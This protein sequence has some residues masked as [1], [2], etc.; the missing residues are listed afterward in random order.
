MSASRCRV[1]CSCG[2]GHGGRS[3]SSSSSCSRRRRGRPGAAGLH[4]AA[5]GDLERGVA[6]RHPLAPLPGQPAQAAGEAGRRSGSFRAHRRSSVRSGVDAATQGCWC[7]RAWPDIVCV[8]EHK[9][10]RQ[11]LTSQLCVAHGWRVARLWGQGR[12]THSSAQPTAQGTPALA[13]RAGRAILL[14]RGARPATAAWPRSAARTP[15]RCRRRRASPA[16]WRSTQVGA[17]ACQPP[18]GC[19]LC[20]ARPPPPRAARFGWR[21]LGVLLPQRLGPSCSSTRCGATA[22]WSSWR[23]WTRRGESWSRTT[24]RHGLPSPPVTQRLCVPAGALA[25]RC[26]GA[27]AHR[28]LASGHCKE[29]EAARGWRA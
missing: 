16:C 19:T 18:Q 14:A 25:A 11:D 28:V 2:S 20:F 27:A 17:P 9:L 4:D 24:V 23:P 6:P 29:E 21:L 15:R 3:S 1:R 10:G 5:R 26:C 8:Q 12:A 13:T 22:R 7:V